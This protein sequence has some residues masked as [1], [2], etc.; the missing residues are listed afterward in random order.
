[1]TLDE[2][3][4]ILETFCDV[5]DGGAPADEFSETCWVYG[6]KQY[7]FWGGPEIVNDEL[8]GAILDGH[9]TCDQLEAIATYMRHMQL[10]G[11]P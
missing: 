5:K 3:R 9:F 6:D 1:M 4:A 2:A 8:N 10:K 7:V 11:T